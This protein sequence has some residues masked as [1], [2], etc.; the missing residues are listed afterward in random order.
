MTARPSAPAAITAGAWC[1]EMPPM[2][3][4]GTSG[5]IRL[6]QEATP[7]RPL[8][9]T[10]ALAP[11]AV[12]AGPAAAAVTALERVA[13]TGPME[14]YDGRTARAAAS[15]P[16]VCVEI[17]RR[18]PEAASWPSSDQAAAEPS[19]STAR[20]SCPM[21]TPYAPTL[22]ASRQKSLTHSRAPAAAHASCAARTSAATSAGLSPLS[23]ICTSRAPAATA[24]A[25]SPLESNTGR[26]PRTARPSQRANIG[27]AAPRS[28]VREAQGIAVAVRGKPV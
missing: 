14:M 19:V 12:E 2:A 6:R 20:S 11:A 10:S 15:S 23:R 5:G 4:S 22:T 8:G 7:S 27:R 9:G 25:T 26:S 28:A 24:S 13:K 3:T 16:Y 17:P 1:T 21:C 18:S